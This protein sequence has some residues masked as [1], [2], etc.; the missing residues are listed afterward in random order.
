MRLVLCSAL[1]PDDW[2]VFEFTAVNA[3]RHCKSFVVIVQYR[4][5][6]KVGWI[7]TFSLNCCNQNLFLNQNCH[8]KWHVKYCKNDIDSEIRCRK[9]R[10]M[11]AYKLITKAF[12]MRMMYPG[13]NSQDSCCVF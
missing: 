7:I 13:K 2:D 9:I 4:R 8:S 1:K 6:L 3:V 10:S 5:Y 11:Y 12:D